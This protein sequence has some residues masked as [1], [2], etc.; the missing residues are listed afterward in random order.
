MP[1]KQQHDSSSQRSA[2]LTAQPAASA[3]L[4]LSQQQ[5]PWQHAQSSQQ[6]QQQPA[7][8]QS[9]SSNQRINS[10]YIPAISRAQ[11]HTAE[12]YRT[13]STAPTAATYISITA[14]HSQHS[15]MVHQPTNYMYVRNRNSSTAMEAPN[16][17]EIQKTS[18]QNNG[19]G[20]N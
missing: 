15:T 1:S 17:V 9:S 14:A 19:K 16:N 11:H 7:Q 2:T 8:H 3:Q 6:Q 12:Q 20:E 18:C 5:R 10:Q 13:A 4:Q